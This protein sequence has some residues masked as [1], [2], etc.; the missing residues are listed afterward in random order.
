MM[1]KSTQRSRAPQMPKFGT[2]HKYCSIQIIIHVQNH[3]V[4]GKGEVDYVHERH[5]NYYSM[6]R[7]VIVN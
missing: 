1:P 4:E 3:I 5:R 6:G 2:I 7:I